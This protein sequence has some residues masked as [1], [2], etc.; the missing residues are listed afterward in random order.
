[1]A[2]LAW[3]ILSAVAP[4]DLATIM[5]SHFVGLVKAAASALADASILATLA[6]CHAANIVAATLPP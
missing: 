3:R 4:F 6:V 5:A 1:M 2:P